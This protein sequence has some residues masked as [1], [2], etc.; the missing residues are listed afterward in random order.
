MAAIRVA[1]LIGAGEHGAS[2]AAGTIRAHR[3]ATQFALAAAGEE[4]DVIS[5]IFAPR[6]NVDKSTFRQRFASIVAHCAQYWALDQTLLD[7]DLARHPVKQT[8]GHAGRPN[9]HLV[10]EE[11]PVTA[12]QRA[13][14]SAAVSAPAER[15]AYPDNNHPGQSCS[16]LSTF[17]LPVIMNVA[18]FPC[19]VS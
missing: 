9:W 7:L 13:A 12:P 8:S 3:E 11:E 5:M 14:S 10:R 19:T 4:A 16:R 6:L 15:G 18:C 2:G 17:S 1:Q